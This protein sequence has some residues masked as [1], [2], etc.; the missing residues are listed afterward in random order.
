MSTTFDHDVLF[1]ARQR[2]HT[3]YPPGWSTWDRHNG[4]HALASFGLPGVRGTRK[5]I[6]RFASRYRAANLYERAKFHTPDMAGPTASGYSDLIRNSLYFAAAESLLT[7]LEIRAV[8]SGDLY[9]RAERDAIL[10]ALRRWDVGA[11][12]LT[13]V[14]ADTSPGRLVEQQVAEYLAGRDAS[15]YVI[16]QAVR[17]SFVHGDLTPNVAGADPAN[18]SAV[19]EV[20]DAALKAM[21]DREF[22]GRM[23]RF[24]EWRAALPAP[25]PGDPDIPF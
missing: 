9:P 3:G 5:R 25:T 13:A 8:Q 14:H 24:E 19:L 16:A 15:P 10:G 17:H 22:G 18:L 23:Q 20:L 1:F 6:T 4:I 2:P 11:R 12:I 7:L 21:M